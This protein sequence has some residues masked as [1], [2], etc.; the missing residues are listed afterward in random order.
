MGKVDKYIVL[1]GS[2]ACLQFSSDLYDFFIWCRCIWGKNCHKFLAPQDLYFRR[3]KE[4]SFFF[5]KNF[6]LLF[7]IQYCMNWVEKIHVNALRQC[8]KQLLI[9]FLIFALV[10]FYDFFFVFHSIKRKKFIKKNKS[11][12]QKSNQQ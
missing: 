4:K 2:S 12:N 10:F 7:L 6:K 11:K 3:C 9:T 8:F 1:R 5:F